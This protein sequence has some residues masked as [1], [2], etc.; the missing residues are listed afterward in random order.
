MSQHPLHNDSVITAITRC[1]HKFQLESSPLCVAYSAGIDSTV[2]LHALRQTGIGRLRAVHVDHRLNADS[3]AWARH[4]QEFCSKLEIPLHVLEVDIDSSMPGGLEAAARDARYAA[5]SGLLEAGETLVTAHHQTDQLETY[6]LQLFRGAGL[7]GLAAMGRLSSKAGMQIARPLLDVSGDDVRAYAV[8][9]SLTW[10]DDPSNAD[11]RFDR[12]YL[13][14]NVLP[15]V[16]ERWPAAE[17]TV[18]RAARLSAEAVE[19]LDTV[20]AEDLHSI[21]DHNRLPLSL[22]RK[23]SVAR[24]KNLLRFALQT[25]GLPIPSEKQLS[26]VILIMLGARSDGSPQA[27]WP[28]VKIYRYKDTLWLYPEG[29]DPA[30]EPSGSLSYPQT[31]RWAAE[32][33]LQMGPV[34]G[35][36]ALGEPGETG[37]AA[38]YINAELDVRFRQGGERLRPGAQSHTRELKN[39]LQERGI[40][41]WMRCHIPLIYSGERLLAVGD[42]WTNAEFG[43]GPGQ[44]SRGVVWTDHSLIA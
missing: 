44:P 16:L 8:A 18:D 29:L 30:S 41:P 21:A 14:H 24:Q 1:L 42:L 27:S 19:I 28:G 11:T 20:A 25:A 33:S 3:A 43:A 9:N 37:I 2:L 10:I 39:L 40:P 35:T 26:E 7:H 23:Q 15:A 36:L 22:L 4:C 13:R 6:L 17:R 31:Y 34:R 32:Q 12:N 38:E 5:I